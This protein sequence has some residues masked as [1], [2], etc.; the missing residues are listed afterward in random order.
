VAKMWASLKMHVD[1]K[2]KEMPSK[3]YWPNT[4]DLEGPLTVVKSERIW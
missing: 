2:N 4:K 3:W 1:L